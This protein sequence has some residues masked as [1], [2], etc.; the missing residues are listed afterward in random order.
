MRELRLS[1]TADIYI[2]TLRQGILEHADNLL[3]R[4]LTSESIAL[5]V[6][7]SGLGDLLEHS[8]LREDQVEKQEEEKDVMMKM[9]VM[10]TTLCLIL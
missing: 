8:D 2:G 10:K 5:G 3:N 1:Y 6:G 7:G 9:E 4:F